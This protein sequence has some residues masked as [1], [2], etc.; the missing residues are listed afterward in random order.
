MR[1]KKRQAAAA[2]LVELFKCSLA[3]LVKDPGRLGRPFHAHTQSEDLYTNHPPEP[4]AQT[5]PECGVE[6][7]RTPVIAHR[8][9]LLAPPPPSPR[10]APLEASSFTYATNEHGPSGATDSDFLMASNI[11]QSHNF[12]ISLRARDD[13]ILLAGWTAAAR[14]PN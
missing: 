1:N 3:T 10:F 5:M 14:A 8:A 12:C 2:A 7:H 13:T 9:L 4:N 11:K 6:W